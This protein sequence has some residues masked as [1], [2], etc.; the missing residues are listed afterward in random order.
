MIMKTALVVIAMAAFN[1]AAF[2]KDGRTYFDAEMLARIREKIDTQPWAAGQ[3]DALRSQS[4]WYLSK[5]D[6]HLWDMVPPPEQMRAINVC[7]AHD[8]PVCGDEITRKAGHY[9]WTMDRDKPFKLTCPV[10]KGTYPENDFQPWNTAGLEGEPETGERVV[11]NGLGWVGPD[12]RRYWFVSYY[13]F[14]QRWSRDILEGMRLLSET[15]V[16]T[17]DPVYARKCAVL[18]VRVADMYDR[19]DYATQCYHEGRFGVNGRI[20]DYIWSTGNNLRI[21]LA[22]DAVYPIFDDPQLLAYLN[23]RAIAQPRER[24][25]QNMLYPMVRDVM[26]GYVAGNQGMHQKTLC[27]L[28][29]V[30]DNDDPQRGPTTAQMRDWI[31]TGPG[32]TED[33]LWNGFWREGLGGESSPSYSSGWCL[34]FYQVAELLPKLGVEIWDNPKLKKMADVGID[35]T[36]AGRFGPCIGDSGGWQ[37]SGPIGITSHLQG[38]AFMRY[39]DVRHA[40]AL[41]RINAKSRDLFIDDFDE[42]R[43]AA[44]V[45]EHGTE[46]ELNTRDLGGY[47]LAILESGDA[48]HRRGAAMYYGFAGGGHG[49]Q[50]RLNIQMW[51]FDRAM[52]TEDGYPTPFTR[53]DFWRWRQT[54]TYKHY[55]VVVDETTQTSLDAG[56]LNTLVATPTVQLMDASAAAAYPGMVSL[57]QRT[58]ALI[59]ISPQDGYLLDIFRV[60][61]G[62]QHDWSFHGPAFF[63]LQ[64]TDGAFGPTQ[65]NGTLAGED[66]PFGAHPPNT[67]GYHGLYNVRRMTPDGMWQATWHKA[68]E[69]LSMTMTMPANCAQQVIVADGSPELQPG[70]PDVIQYVLGR[71]QSTGDAPLSSN[72]VAIVEPHR[73]AANVRQVRH[74][75]A[76]H[77]PPG[78]IGVAVE[79]HGEVDLVHSSPLSGKAVV[80]H[81]AE[82]P[83]AAQ[84]EF[85]IVTLDAEGVKRAVIVDGVSLR[86]G[87]IELH[88]EPSPR[89]R[90]HAVDLAN[91]R[92]IIDQLL[93][94]PAAWQDSVAIFG[95]ELHSTSYTIVEAVDQGDKTALHFGDTLLIIGMGAVAQV[96]GNAL[97]S[98]RD[99][100]GYGRVDGG[101]HQGRWLYNES[102]TRGFRINA[103][104]GRTFALDSTDVNLDDVF[105]DADGDG[106]RLYWISGLGPGDTYRMPATTHYQR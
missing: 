31:M 12:D 55:C 83:L 6:Q 67:S 23:E 87:D 56:D 69:D 80:W 58:S 13:I 90:V 46:L 97:L 10:C 64:V 72:Y 40:Q 82:Q 45:A 20:S 4:A 36:I 84:A 91:N 61:G 29:I 95:N 99:L 41:A 81:G 28:A 59:D 53:V 11:D 78:A 98:D 105:I 22:Y 100:S 51:A 21:A 35:M 54:G 65:T 1:S 17:G 63:E 19:F 16:A 49:H 34:N 73:G 86:Y 25:E 39:G 48:E 5:S 77:T 44:V 24:I 104:Q 89:G 79:R 27:I 47:G 102:R 15:Y 85:A 38:P 74:L 94:D 62:S 92:I 26:S 103:I 76:V 33:L 60:R 3:V 93:S 88:A 71:N 18:L 32:R 2:G 66:I 43:V 50:D 8:C 101:K 9:P 106:R 37:G 52:M 96:D 68:D 14:W 70:N 57:Y 42:Q 75:N 7:I 30:L